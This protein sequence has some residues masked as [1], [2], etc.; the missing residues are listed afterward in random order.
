MAIGT[1]PFPLIDLVAVTLIQRRMIHQL[2]GHY[3]F[4]ADKDILK[5]WLAAITGSGSSLFSGHIFASVLKF[6]PLLGHAFG[7]LSFTITAGAATYAVGKIFIQHFE[8]GG[9]LLT[10]DPIAVRDHYSTYL[11]EG[12][13]VAHELR[14]EGV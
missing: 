6:T 10:F 8:A 13:E 3:G 7:T 11:K 14:K 1:I 9:T 5:A 2:G 4:R 12:Q